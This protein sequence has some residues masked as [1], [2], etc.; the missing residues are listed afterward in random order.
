MHS[1]DTGRCGP[2]ISGHVLLGTYLIVLC[3]FFLYSL[4]FSSPPFLFLYLLFVSSSLPSIPISFIFTSFLSSIPFY[5]LFPSFLPSSS[6]F[7]S[8]FLFFSLSLFCFSRWTYYIAKLDFNSNPC[9]VILTA[10]TGMN[11]HGSLTFYHLILVCMRVC[12]RVRAQIYDSSL[13]GTSGMCA[14]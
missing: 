11:C 3:F 9:C 8:F 5:F 14:S 1:G 4:P 13:C 12:V 7:L 10:V 2:E 6:F